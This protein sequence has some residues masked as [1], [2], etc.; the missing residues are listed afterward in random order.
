MRLNFDATLICR[1]G[2]ASR[3]AVVSETMHENEPKIK[4]LAFDLC[5]NLTL[6]NFPN[7]PYACAVTSPEPS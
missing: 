3:F 6:F 4:L 7:L 1:G 2:I 5:Y